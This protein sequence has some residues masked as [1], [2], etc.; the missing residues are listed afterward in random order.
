MH[1]MTLINVQFISRAGGLVS[2]TPYGQYSKDLLFCYLLE[3]KLNNYNIPASCMNYCFD[4][5]I[6]SLKF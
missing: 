2:A 1:Q 4:S 3:T 5:N 6:N